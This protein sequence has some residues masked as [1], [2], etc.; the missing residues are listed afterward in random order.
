MVFWWTSDDTA[1]GDQDYVPTPQPAP[2]PEFEPGSA[3]Q[4]LHIPLVNDGLA[5]SRE[6]FYVYLGRYDAL[7]GR[8]E[9]VSSARI[10]IVDDDFR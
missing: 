1:L 9:P 4:T 8:L 7:R 6:S 2:G 5:E 10:D 3:N